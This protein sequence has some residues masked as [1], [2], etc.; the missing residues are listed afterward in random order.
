M[1]WLR[2]CSTKSIL[3]RVSEQDLLKLLSH[4][5]SFQNFRTKRRLPI[6][7]FQACRTK[8]VIECLGVCF[9]QNIDVWT[10]GFVA[11]ILF[12]LRFLCLPGYLSCFFRMRVVFWFC[13]L[14]YVF[15]LLFCRESWGSKWY[16]WTGSRGTRPLPFCRENDHRDQSAIIYWSSH[17]N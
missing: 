5:V 6:K 2:K 16:P 9:Y 17:I 7:W 11:S 3:P 14:S 1:M 13:F 12:F 10:F 8:N 15:Q 4:K